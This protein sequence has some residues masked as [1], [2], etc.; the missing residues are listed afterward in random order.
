MNVKRYIIVIASL[1]GMSGVYQ[2]VSADVNQLVENCF[3]CH[4]KDGVSTY[5]EIPTIAGYSA[6]YLTESFAIYKDEERPCAE[7]EYQQGKDKGSKS[8][9]CKIAKKLSEAEIEEVAEFFAGKPFVRAKQTF[10]AD[11]AA[12]GKKIHGASCK[13]CHEDGG[14]SADDDA[15]ILAGQWMPYLRETFK[16]YAAGTRT[17]PKKMKVKM[18]KL[19]DAEVESLIHYYGSFQ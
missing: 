14:S 1:V 18:E 15:G 12:Q 7:T 2:M 3:G 17:Q 4:G 8:D 6:Y 10:D 5:P 19:D 11:K 13:K 9:M 16:E